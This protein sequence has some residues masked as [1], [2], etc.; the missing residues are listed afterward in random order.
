MVC[1]PS[2]NLA[3]RKT[4]VGFRPKP[5]PVS[6]SK[7]TAQS[8]NSSRSTTTGLAMG[9]SPFFTG[10]THI[11]P[12]GIAPKVPPDRRRM[13]ACCNLRTKEA[14][15][16]HHCRVEEGVCYPLR[17]VVVAQR[18]PEPPL[19]LL[20][21]DIPVPAQLPFRVED[22]SAQTATEVPVVHQVPHALVP[23]EQSPPWQFPL[24]QLEAVTHGPL[25]QDAS[26]VALVPL[27]QH[28]PAAGSPLR[29]MSLGAS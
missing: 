8:S 14:R 21:A 12:P 16:L 10:G 27:L 2:R 29:L 13:A 20:D 5:R 1:L 15:T 25:Q 28:A 6:G 23:E 18:P 19:H 22:P 3:T 17:T 4:P 7:R 9:F 24:E 26:P 11:F